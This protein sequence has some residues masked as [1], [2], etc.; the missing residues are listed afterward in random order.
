[1]NMM[2]NLGG[3]VS[4]WVVGIIIDQ[5]VDRTGTLLGDMIASVGAWNL[6]FLITS[7]FC[8]L[9]AA[10]WLFVD[11]VT[12]LDLGDPERIAQEG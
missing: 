10:C 6:T 7:G 4:P 2:G 12:P 1:M 5:N 8:L 3:F 11:P 9:G